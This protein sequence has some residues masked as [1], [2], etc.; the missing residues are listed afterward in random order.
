MNRRDLLLGGL[1]ASGAAALPSA[2]RA[3]SPRRP[4]ETGQPLVVNGLDTSELSRTYVEMQRSAGVDCWHKS[5]I[6][7]RTFADAYNF[8]DANPDLI[9]VTRTAGEIRQARTDG[10]LALVFG[11]QGAEPVSGPRAGRSD[12]WSDPPRSE[13]R[14]YYEMGLRIAGIAYQITN[15]FGGGGLDPQVGLTRAGRR[16]VEEVHH[17]KMVLDIGGHTGDQASLDALAMTSGIPVICSHGA[18]RKFAN[19]SRNLS[20]AVIDGIAKTGGVIGIPA[21]SDF[22][23]RGKEMANVEPSPLGGI[24]DFLK[25]AD[26]LKARIGAAHVSW[27]PDYTYGKKDD[28]DYALFGPDVMDKGPRRFLRGFEDVT[29]LVPTVRAGLTDHGWS[30]AEIAGFMGE[31]WIRV[32]QRVW[33]S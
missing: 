4:G 11:W 5:M 18:T 6:D 15:A 25:H 10:K 1:V 19:S 31:N 14:G 27:G 8:V 22:V 30:E 7:L 12:W 17:L 33:G 9:R 23:V 32:Y 26:Y 3:A 16:Y 21:I 2:V 24:A 29:K 13:L 20:D 28:R